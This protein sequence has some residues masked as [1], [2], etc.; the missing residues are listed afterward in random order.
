MKDG[1]ILQGGSIV[2]NSVGK[3]YEYVTSESFQHGIS[4]VKN[5]FN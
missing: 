1:L 2:E 4:K 5:W 3:I